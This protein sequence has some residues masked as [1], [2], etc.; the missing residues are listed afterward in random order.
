MSDEAECNHLSKIQREMKVN[1]VL[2]LKKSA[3]F[4]SA[5]LRQ[6]IVNVGCSKP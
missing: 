6:W 1:E 4:H 3:Q 2:I 5:Y